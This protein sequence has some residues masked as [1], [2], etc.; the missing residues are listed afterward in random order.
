MRLTKT[1]TDVVRLLCHGFQSRDV[2]RELALTEAAYDKHLT[3]VRRK[4]GVT[5]MAQLGAWAFET[6]VVRCSLAK[7]AH[8]VVE[9]AESNDSQ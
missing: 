9:V 1:E 6:G 5:S 2:R 7:A 3:N 8:A 4:A